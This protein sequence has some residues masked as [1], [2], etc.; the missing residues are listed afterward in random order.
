MKVPFLFEEMK[1]PYFIWRIESPFFWP[2]I[3]K[4]V[5]EILYI[6]SVFF[7]LSIENFCCFLT[8][9][10]TLWF[11]FWLFRLIRFSLFLFFLVVLRQAMLCS[12]ALVY[13]R[14]TERSGA[15]VLAIRLYII[16]YKVCTPYNTMHVYLRIITSSSKVCWGFC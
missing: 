9:H 10:N 13:I 3:I 14:R 1:S 2:V 15:S 8:G 7:A 16:L 12:P 4:F 6:L 11:L 5:F